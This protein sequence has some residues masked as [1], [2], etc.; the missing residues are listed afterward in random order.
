MMKFFKELFYE[1]IIAFYEGSNVVIGALMKLPFLKDKVTEE[2]YGEGKKTIQNVLGGVML[3][4]KLLLEFVGKLV[5][6]V[7]MTWIPWKILSGLCP[8]I[9]H[10][11]ELA[12]M[13]FFFVLSTVCGSLTN[14]TLFTVSNRDFMMLSVIRVNE[15]KHYV[16]R[17]LYKM[18]TGLIFYAPALMIVGVT[19]LNAILL[20][21]VTTALRPVGELISILTHD[22]FRRIH[23]VKGTISGSLMALSVVIAYL[24][25]FYNRRVFYFWYHITGPAVVIVSLLLCAV[26]MYILW[27]YKHYDKIA[28]ESIHIKRED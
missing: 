12:V 23:K 26:S 22:R 13:Y 9:L 8:L 25:P 20:S 1:K 7:L 21:L 10:Q 4:G 16:G 2:W 3:F 27:N 11:Q 14:T 15:S 5:Y 17:M 28:K 18:G 19:P 6:I 24:I